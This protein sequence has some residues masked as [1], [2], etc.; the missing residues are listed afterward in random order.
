MIIAVIGAT[1]L[2]GRTI[3]KI[4]QEKN[5][6]D[7]KNILCFAS[8]KSAGSTLDI[9]GHIYTVQEL[10]EENINNHITFAIFA[11]GGT[12]SK[13]WAHFFTKNGTIVIDNSS[14][15]R[16]NKNVPLVVPEINFNIVSLKN[17]LIANPNCSS[18]ALTLPLFVLS[19]LANIK[20]VIVSTYQAASGAGNKGIEDLENNTTYKFQY[21]LKNNLIPHIDYFLDNNYT[22]E[23]DKLMFEPTKILGKKFKISATAV[24]VPI[25]NSHSESINVELDREIDIRE[26]QRLLAENEAILLFDNP[27]QNK[28]PMPI[29][30]NATDKIVVGRIRRDISKKNS[31][32]FFVS[33]DN[34]KKGAAL[35]AAQILEKYKNTFFND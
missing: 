22:Y 4:L 33:M 16:R 6:G 28:Y 8:K 10:C 26:F 18:I 32:T 5:L 34:I 7:E 27:K 9:D 14:M 24:R 17:K 1:G 23:E 30:A 25:K 12:V 31:L 2:V 29:I 35:N 20:R 11:A 19:K 13:Q 15:F 3:M 21:S